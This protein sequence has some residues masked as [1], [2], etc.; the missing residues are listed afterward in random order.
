VSRVRYKHNTQDFYTGSLKPKVHPVCQGNPRLTLHYLK[1][2][3]KF[4]R[5]HFQNMQKHHL[6]LLNHIR[7]NTSRAR[8]PLKTWKT[9]EN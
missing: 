3:T 8:L 9:T 4:T 6:R 7:I 5:L 1:R 2:F